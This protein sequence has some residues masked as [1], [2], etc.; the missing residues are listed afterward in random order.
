MDT[1][2]W[3]EFADGSVKIT[4]TIT[5]ARESHKGICLGKGGRT[6]KAVRNAAQADLQAML[7][8]RVHLS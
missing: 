8:R 7:E 1:D 6:I 3:E 2:A 4:Q 5:V